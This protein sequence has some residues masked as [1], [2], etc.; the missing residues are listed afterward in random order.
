MVGVW[1][2]DHSS[3]TPG[4]SCDDS[5]LPIHCFLLLPLLLPITYIISRRSFSNCHPSLARWQTLHFARR[6][7]E[8][9]GPIQRPGSLGFRIDQTPIYPFSIPA[10]GGLQTSASPSTWGGLCMV[11][12]RLVGYP[13]SDTPPFYVLGFPHEERCSFFRLG[14]FK[15]GN[16]RMETGRN[17]S[18]T[19]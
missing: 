1:V 13:Q 16:L 19:S 6:P 12:E 10:Q 9:T 5:L 4:S 2:A 11:D 7:T 3:H 8:R 15:N 18:S 17:G 14:G